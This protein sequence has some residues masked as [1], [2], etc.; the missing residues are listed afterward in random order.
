MEVQTSNWRT[1]IFYN[2]IIKN[3]LTLKYFF[4]TFD[5]SD[6]FPTGVLHKL[7]HCCE[8]KGCGFNP[9]AFRSSHSPKTCNSKRASKPWPKIGGRTER[10]G[11]WCLAE[12]GGCSES[13]LPKLLPLRLYACTTPGDALSRHSVYG[14]VKLAPVTQPTPTAARSRCARCELES[15]LYSRHSLA[16]RAGG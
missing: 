16:G 14:R 8:H 15:N 5:G 10:K 6:P 9:W 13:R 12:G 4:V 7:R 2:L 1:N 11:P 3:I